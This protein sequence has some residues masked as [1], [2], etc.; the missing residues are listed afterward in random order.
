V[1]DPH[2]TREL[3]RSLMQPGVRS[4][5]PR[6]AA[7]PG[8]PALQPV[9]F[10]ELL[11]SAPEPDWLWHGMLAAGSVT[12]LAGAPK[13]GKTTLIAGLLQALEIGSPFLG[14]ETAG[15]GAL[16]LTEETGTTL[17]E[18]TKAFRLDE[19]PRLQGIPREQSFGLAWERLVAAAVA[20][21]EANDLGLIVVD[22]FPGL[23]ELEGEDENTAGAVLAK[24]RPL[25][26]AATRGLSVLIVGHERKSGGRYGSGVRG[27][28]ALVGAVD[29]VAELRRIGRAEE[30]ARAL[31]MVSRYADTPPRLNF[32]LAAGGFRLRE[33][34][35]V[36]GQ[37]RTLEALQAAGCATAE[38]I[39]DQTKQDKTTVV[40]HLGTVDDL[41]ISGTGKRGDPKL[42]C[43]A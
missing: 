36:S 21:A 25:Q 29:V 18:K 43:V 35:P 30:N 38:E 3:L 13:A 27:S 28:N 12:L 2:E 22:T 5:G 40:R 26:A 31:T 4:N 16:V 15:R 32:E 8:I 24:L 10:A 7:P 33:A 17:G 14:L 1:S 11:A 42:Y 9:T 41:V 34:K 37:E 19:L 6:P 23:A 20:S 39:A